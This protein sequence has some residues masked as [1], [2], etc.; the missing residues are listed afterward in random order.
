M[1]LGTVG[2][3]RARCRRHSVRIQQR[4]RRAG[5]HRPG[6]HEERQQ[7]RQQLQ[8]KLFSV[9]VPFQCF[10]PLLDLMAVMYDLLMVGFSCISLICM[11][12]GRLLNNHMYFAYTI[13]WLIHLFFLF[14]PFFFFCFCI[15]LSFEFYFFLLL[16]WLISW[17]FC[18]FE[19]IFR[20]LGTLLFCSSFLDYLIFKVKMHCL[21]C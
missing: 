17:A 12:R 4:R 5:Q 2:V 14:S 10:W 21:L 6:H 20:F 3:R 11:F 19:V 9:N 18:W 8:R 16:L 13:G 1:C 15:L 7:Y